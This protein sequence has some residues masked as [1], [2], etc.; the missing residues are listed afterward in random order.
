MWLKSRFCIRPGLHLENRFSHDAALIIS[1]Y[2]QNHEDDDQDNDADNESD[3]PSP[4]L[5]HQCNH[6]YSRVQSSQ[7]YNGDS[8]YE[9]ESK[10]DDDEEEETLMNGSY[11]G[12]NS[13]Q[14]EITSNT[15]D[16][17]TYNGYSDEVSPHSHSP[18]SRNFFMDGSPPKTVSPTLSG[19]SVSG[20]ISPT[21]PDSNVMKYG[22]Y[23]LTTAMI[24]KRPDTVPSQVNLLI[25]GEDQT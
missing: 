16:S 5:P 1:V 25:S 9:A 6:D 22:Q 19:D 21:T 2:F 14:G 15:P 3:T 12:N 24:E 4:P 20:R 11:H 18:G 17:H 8:G 13:Y 7:E 10:P 23:G